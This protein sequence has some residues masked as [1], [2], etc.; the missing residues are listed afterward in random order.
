MITGIGT[1]IIEIS[2]IKKAVTNKKFVDR[3]FTSSEQNYCISTGRSEERFA[4]RFAAKEAIA[5]AI[6]SS[7]SWLD[8]EILAEESGKPVVKLSGKAA[9]ITE[10]RHVMVSISHCR[11][12]AMACAIMVSD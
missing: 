11:T 3:I 4:G 12:Y 6:G 7:L 9:E 10:G 2:R 8:V 1:D 5:K